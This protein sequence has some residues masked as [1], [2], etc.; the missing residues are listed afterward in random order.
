MDQAPDQEKGQKQNDERI[1]IGGIAP[2]IEPKGA[3]E[4]PH[5]HALQT[6]FLVAAPV[7][8]LGV[9][10]GLLLKEMPL[11]GAAAA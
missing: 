3:G 4:R 2:Q 9:L 8:A 6:V 5:A 1:G 7:A 10:V 11:R